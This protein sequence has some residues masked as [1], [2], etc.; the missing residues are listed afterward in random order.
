MQVLR[1]PEE[2]F[3]DLAGWDFAPRYQEV[4]ARDG[5]RLRYH[6]VDEGPRDA[7]PVL[8]L[9]GNP[10]WSYIHREMI[11]GL[12]AKGHRVV[13]LDLMGLGRSDKPA[14]PDDYTLADHV[15]WMRQW[16]EA[17]D[18]R[19]ITLYCQDWGGLAG[20]HLL[21]LFPDRFARVVASNTGVPVG[22]GAS[23]LMQRWLAFSQS[24]PM[25]PCAQMIGSMVAGGL[26]EGAKRAYDAPYPDASYQAGVKKFPLLIPVQP[27]NPG[28]PMC[29]ALWAFLETWQKPF[30]T[31]FGALDPIA[32][33]P[34]AH[35]RFQERVPGAK[36]QPH[37][38]FERANH[39][40]QEDVPN[41][42]VEVIDGFVRSRG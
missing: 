23:P 41:E 10:S 36:G 3:A 37:V 16:L 29:K 34:G 39:F 11:R 35:L 21:P 24:V 27:D 4:S 15:E 5:T 22:E 9:H 40:I 7:A 14:S 19:E 20:L 42:L 8:L 13:A 6:F 33:K 28:V 1:T 30:L 18:L 25:I 2:R 32:A 26:S 31:V 12:A 38:L 17:V